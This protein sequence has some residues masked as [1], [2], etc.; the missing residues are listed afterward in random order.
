MKTVFSVV[1]YALFGYL[2]SV[3]GITAFKDMGLFLSLL[4]ILMIVDLTSYIQ[5]RRGD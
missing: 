3:G 1:M 4:G 2:L 5:G